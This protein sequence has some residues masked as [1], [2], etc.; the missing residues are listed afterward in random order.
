MKF[1]YLVDGSVNRNE[2]I[3]AVSENVFEKVIVTYKPGE[4]TDDSEFDNTKHNFQ[5]EKEATALIDFLTKF[6]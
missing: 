3:Q 5:D 4:I 2:I 1:I 6:C